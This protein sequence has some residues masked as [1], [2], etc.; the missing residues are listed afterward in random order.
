MNLQQAA[1]AYLDSLAATRTMSGHTL[2]AHQSDLLSL[3]RRIGATSPADSLY[4]EKLVEFIVWQRQQG[5]APATIRRRASAIRG[6]CDWLRRNG[7]IVDDPW[8]AADIQIRQPRRLPRPARKDSVRRLPASLC[9]SARVSAT[10]VPRGPFTRPYEAN[11]L[12]AVILM[13]GTGMRVGEVAA[14]RCI[15]FDPNAKSL[16]VNGKGARERQVFLSSDWSVGL[17]GAQLTTRQALNVYHEGI[18]FNRDGKEI[19]TA[20][21]RARLHKETRSAGLFEKITPHMLRHTAAT[22]LV[23]HGV[24]IRFVQRLLGH[25]SLTTTEQY[26]QVA[27]HSLRRAITEANVIGQVLMHNS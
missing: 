13:L 26:T 11:T 3:T 2:R 14:L 12:V 1:A 22:Q 23:E 19:T 17:I 9:S 4:A 27:D 5:L 25:A 7:L 10:E 18:L 15:D 24:D 21:I 16:R 20:S 6:F 8:R